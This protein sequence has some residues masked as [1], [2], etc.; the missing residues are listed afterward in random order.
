M[1]LT[2]LFSPIPE[3]IYSQ[4]Y[5]SN[6]FFKNIRAYTEKM[7]HYK[8]AHIAIIGVKEERGT[9]NNHGS[10]KGPD[11]IRKKLYALKKGTGAYRIVDLGNLNNGID[12]DETYTRL[13]EVCRMLLESNVLPLILG[14]T[15]DLDYGQ[16]RGYEE[17]EKL[18]S[19]LNVDA[20]L[21]LDDSKDVTASKKHIHKILLHEPN[22]L[23]SYTHLAHQTYLIDAQA[24]SILEKLYF[25]AF[26]IG[27]MRTNFAEMEP[28][29]RN[30]D[31]LSFDVTA[32]KSAD[33]PGNANAQPFGLTGEEACQI[34]WYA[35]LNEKLSS[36]G[37]YEYNPDVDDAHKKTASVIATMIWYFI[38]GY[39]H[40]KGDTSFRSND[41]LKYVVSMPVEPETITFYKSKVTEKWWMEVAYHRP[42][43]RYARNT[44][45]P[46]SYNDYLV[47]S[48]GE[49]PERYI[50]ALGKLS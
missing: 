35:G 12:L 34:C 26:R 3:P 49:I 14:A 1:D 28:A 6:S 11:E 29:I 46:C 5:P 32:I 13:S 4:P 15:H 25:E 40:R 27:Q 48:K 30:A 39:Y 9:S 45:V 8:D 7:P 18:V 19:L 33:A 38:E 24:A 2:I 20:F 10:S 17:M 36:A 21:D 37:F 31:I 42:G 41:F 44:M 23:L 50:S 43:A 47:A 22:Y 16:Y